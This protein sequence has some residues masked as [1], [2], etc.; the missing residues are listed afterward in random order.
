MFQRITLLVSTFFLLSNNLFSQDVWL[1]NYFSPVSGCGLTTTEVVNV[2]INN[3]SASILPSNT[4]NVSYTIDGG[5]LT[6]QLLSSNLFPGAS[7]NFA[8]NVKANLNACGSHSIKVWVN[9][10]GDPNP[11]NDTLN[12]VVQNDCPIVPGAIVPST[13]VCD[14]LNSGNL[15]LVG[16]S[17]GTILGWQTSTNGGA[18]WTGTGQ[19]ATT[20]SYSGLTQSTMYQVVIDGGMCVDDTSGVATLTVQPALV[21]GTIAGSDSLCITSAT[22]VLTH[23]GASG[24]ILSWEYSDNNGAS[25]NTIANTTATYNYSSLIATR[26][27]RVLLDGGFCPDN[28]SDT[29]VIFVEQLTFPGVLVGSDSLC[30]SNA[31]GSISVTGT[32]GTVSFWESSTTN[33]ASW[34]TINTTTPTINYTGLTSTTWYRVFT[35]G[36]QCPSYYS[37][38]AV[39]FVQ[40]V[41]PQPT[42]IGSDSMC[43]TN[44]AGSLTLTG[45]VS[46]IISWQSSSNNGANWTLISNSTSLENYNGLTNTTWYRVL[47]DGGICPNI[48]SDTAIIFVEQ[49]T[50]AGT[51]LGSDSVCILNASG[52]LTVTGNI[53]TVSYWESSINNGGSWSPIAN[54]STTENYSGLLQDIWYRVYTDGGFCPSYFSDTAIITVVP[55]ITPGTIQGADTLCGFAP[56]DTLIYSGGTGSIVF[57]ESSIDGGSNWNT[58]GTSSDTLVYLGALATIW[59]RVFVE[60]EICTGIFADTAI[61]EIFPAPS[62]GLLLMDDTICLGTSYQLDLIGSDAVSYNWESSID[63][64]VWTPIVGVNDSI[65]IVSNFSAETFFRVIVENGICPGDTSN[66]ILLSLFPTS[67]SDAGNGVEITQGDSTQLIGVGGLLGVWTPGSTL[68]DSLIF[69]PLAFPLITTTYTYTIIDSNGCLSQ[70]S[71]VISVVAPDVIDIKNVITANNDNYNDS[72]I[73]EGVQYFPGTFVIVFNIYGEEVYKSEDYQNDWKGTYKDKR[74]PNGTYY[75]TVIPGGTEDTIKGTLTILGDE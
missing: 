7:W 54:T 8:F 46:S 40:A 34:T 15:N 19:T 59:Y 66:V 75:Y 2:L 33:G 22:G 69:N 18:S 10:P 30:A 29:A 39:I 57:W 24:P 71:V 21:T 61:V 65:N 6:Q 55:M 14:G 31:S 47:I 50:E 63:S 62:A 35:D 12:W 23:S 38:S 44:V 41:P 58:I 73:I 49:L 37:D 1:Q 43:V 20:L 74:L 32:V 64:V 68:T 16:W 26:W 70:D 27:Y 3:N 5:S 11:L 48:Y 42:L 4:I 72:W 9:R 25:W 60:G 56:S 67:F 52:S 28:Y 36:G 13:T 51:V 17:N 45:T 53:G